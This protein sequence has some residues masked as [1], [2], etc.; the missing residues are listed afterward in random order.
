MTVK[1]FKKIINKAA[2][3]I[4]AMVIGSILADYFVCG[5]VYALT[6]YEWVGLGFISFVC[7]V[8]SMEE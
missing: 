2:L 8:N 6:W 4:S 5:N 7:I 1:T 3:S